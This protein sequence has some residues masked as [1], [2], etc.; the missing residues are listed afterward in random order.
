M[1][2]VGRKQ[3]TKAKQRSRAEAKQAKQKFDVV[4]SVEKRAA[5]GRG[6]PARKGRS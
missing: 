5:T 3:F 4:K 6:K 2:Q 1:G